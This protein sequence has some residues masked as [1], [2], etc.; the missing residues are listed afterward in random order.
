MQEDRKESTRMPREYKVFLSF[1]EMEKLKSL[2]VPGYPY[3]F[4]ELLELLPK[5][6]D[7]SVPDKSDLRSFYIDSDRIYPGVWRHS[8]EVDFELTGELKVGYRWS[9]YDCASP[10]YP[11]PEEV[12]EYGYDYSDGGIT[13]KD[14][15]GAVYQ[16][17]VNLVE[18]G[19]CKFS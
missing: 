17:L 8:L 18:S 12:P 13:S 15:L 14:W 6:I 3:T 16:L 1:E 19:L 9:Y 2:G 5:T 11:F 4:Q 10:L 7:I